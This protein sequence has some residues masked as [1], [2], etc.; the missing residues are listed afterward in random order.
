MLG[1][2]TGMGRVV[3]EPA[4]PGLPPADSGRPPA[5]MGLVRVKVR[6]RLRVRVEG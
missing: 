5:D 4:E 2:A 1:A 6:L 3:S